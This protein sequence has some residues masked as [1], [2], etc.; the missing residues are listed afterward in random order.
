MY[1][2]VHLYTI[3][4]II[5]VSGLSPECS[6]PSPLETEWEP[7][8]VLC[9]K[10][11]TSSG[12]MYSA[13]TGD[14]DRRHREISPCSRGDI[15]TDKS[16]DVPHTKETQTDQV[17]GSIYTHV[18]DIIGELAGKLVPQ[19]R[20]AVKNSWVLLYTNTLAPVI[21]PSPSLQCDTNQPTTNWP[22]SQ[23]TSNQPTNQT[24]LANQ[25]PTARWL[26]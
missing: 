9:A 7:T 21:G 16:A 18:G 1:S 13:Q 24:E 20:T 17:G 15:N 23:P 6:S 14:T 26:C 3:M 25:P 8:D 12:F 11:I 22:I 10:S 19:H 5:P 4:L 2:D